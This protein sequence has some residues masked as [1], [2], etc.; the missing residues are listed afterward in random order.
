MPNSQLDQVHANLRRL[1]RRLPQLPVTE[2][3]IVRAAVILGRDTSTL[4]DRLLQ[5]AGLTEGEFRVL[6][7]LLAHG[8]RANAGD[9][10]ASLA[11]SPANLTRIADA[12]V[13]RGYV[14]RRP[15]AADRRRML[16]QLKPAGRRMLDTLLPGV[17]KEV[18]AL[19][20]GFSAAE[21]KQM[22]EFFRRLLGS[23]EALNLRNT[24][25][26]VDAA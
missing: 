3:L 21:K 10:C 15:D 18:T 5:P 16:L 2:S 11:Q 19:F 12:L 22:L 4:I 7:S 14:S 24:T 9:L 26:G 20:D 25:A 23:I 8:D 13:K 17:C 1:N 6:M